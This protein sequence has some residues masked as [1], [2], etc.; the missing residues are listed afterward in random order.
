MNS[1]TQFDANTNFYW[2]ERHKK[3]IDQSLNNL[4]GKVWTFN[5]PIL[6]LNRCWLKLETIT[7][8]ELPIRLPPDNSEEA[9]ELAKFHQLINAGENDLLALQKCWDEFGIEDFHRALR[10]SWDCKANGNNGWTFKKYIST[11]GQYRQSIAL[12][13]LT[14]PLI[15]LGRQHSKEDHIVQWINSELITKA[16]LRN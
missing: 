4:K 10:N 15:L 14:I 7:A 2:P 9:P 12:N 1:F 6:L 8:S 11:I 5:F 16:S 3:Q 13:Q